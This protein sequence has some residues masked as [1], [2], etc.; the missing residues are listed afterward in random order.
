VH[1]IRKPYVF[2]RPWKSR[3][4]NNFAEET[5]AVTTGVLALVV[6]CSPSLG[7]QCSLA[8]LPDARQS[9]IVG[10]GGFRVHLRLSGSSSSSRRHL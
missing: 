6:S 3:A 8:S 7:L 1:R 2:G 5:V 10:N 4:R 9:R